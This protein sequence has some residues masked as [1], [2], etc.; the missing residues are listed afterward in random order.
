MRWPARQDFWIGINLPWQRY[1]GD[2]G[3]NRWQPDGG[4][5]QP[6]R[7]AALRDALVGIADRG[8]AVVRWF[9]LADGRAGLRESPTGELLGL[10][11]AVFCDADAA[12]EELERAGLP[13]VF[14][15]FDFHWFRR[16]RVIDGV[17]VGGRG[18]LAS[19]P[20]LRPHLLE[21]VVSPLLDRYGRHPAI[22]AWDVINEPEWATRGTRLLPRRSD[23]AWTAMRGFIG[24]VVEHIH[25][26]T[27]HAATVGSASTGTL[28]LVEG[29][30]LDV[31]QAH[32]Y[33]R[34]APHAPLDR[35]VAGLALDRP[36]ILGEFPTRGSRWPPGAIL[37]TARRAG[38]AG[39]MAWSAL[40]EDEASDRDAL[41]MVLRTVA[42]GS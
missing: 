25:R 29:L 2:F 34:L 23:A 40:A 3:A 38:Y 36:L 6:G 4:V 18:A 39:A 17:Q 11:D 9:M 10:D 41:E 16:A 8:I 35:P 7:R 1:G 22:L 15:L 5:G 14:V 21:R 12:L 31:Y 33:D 19:D 13:A 32:W 28:P 37:E 26:Q 20:A 30:G 27:A 42:R 24:D